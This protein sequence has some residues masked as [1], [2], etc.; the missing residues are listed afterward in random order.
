MDKIT[1]NHSTNEIEDM[2]ILILEQFWKN[3][4]FSAPLYGADLLNTLM[5]ETSKAWNLNNLQS[6]LS[7]ALSNKV[8]GVNTPYC[9]VGSWKAF[10]CWHT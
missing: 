4:T 5:D 3:V 9:Y 8:K 1:D 6:V 7:D 10:F 2:V